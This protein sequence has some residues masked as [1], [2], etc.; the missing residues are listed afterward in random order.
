MTRGGSHDLAAPGGDPWRGTEP[1]RGL[2]HLSLEQVDKVDKV[3]EETAPCTSAEWKPTTTFTGHIADNSALLWQV[4]LSGALVSA[5]GRSGYNSANETAETTDS[6]RSGYNKI[7]RARMGELTALDGLL[8]EW[9]TTGAGVFV[10]A[11]GNPCGNTDVTVPQ[12]LD[13]DTA[14]ATGSCFHGGQYYLV[15]AGGNVELGEKFTTPLG[16]ESVGSGSVRANLLRQLIAG[17]VRTSELD[18]GHHDTLEARDMDSED[19]SVLIDEGHIRLPVCGAAEALENWK[20]SEETG[21]RSPRFP[22]NE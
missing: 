7:K 5:S 11:S 2:Y 22:C 15:Q 6:G 21:T 10:M 19:E 18:G 14:G 17:S 13:E 4:L 20:R 12:Y 8:A 9:S 16:W 3:M 1:Q